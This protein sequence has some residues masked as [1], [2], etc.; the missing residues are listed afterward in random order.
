MF[1][2][3]MHGEDIIKK[4]HEQL[5]GFKEEFCLRT[6]VWYYLNRLERVCVIHNK[7]VKVVQFSAGVRTHLSKDLYKITAAATTLLENDDVLIPA[8]WIN[9]KSL[10][11]Y[12]KSGYSDKE[13]ALPA[14]WE[15]IDQVRIRAVDIGGK[16]VWRTQ[17]VVSGHI[18]LTLGKDEMLLVER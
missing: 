7:E 4:D 8:L 11:A 9:Q 13:W 3:S 10:I 1:G 12:S 6:A 16:S 15:A 17:K 2:T 5:S 14:G 18:T